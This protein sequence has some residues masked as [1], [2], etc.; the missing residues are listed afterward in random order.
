[1]WVCAKQGAAGVAGACCERREK[2]VGGGEW[3][4]NRGAACPR[5]TSWAFFATLTA[6]ASEGHPLFILR[7]LAQSTNAA[8]YHGAVRPK[9]A[10][11]SLAVSFLPAHLSLLVGLFSG[12]GVT[13]DAQ[14]L[15]FNKRRSRSPGVCA[16]ASRIRIP[17]APR[18]GSVP[19]QAPA[20]LPLGALR[21]HNR[22]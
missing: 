8:R 4:W 20:K 18:L 5:P 13:A 3:W 17:H 10:A 9:L 19:H 14:F 21:L 12:S 22:Q 16:D 7:S 1:M 2:A 11:P 6:A 15:W